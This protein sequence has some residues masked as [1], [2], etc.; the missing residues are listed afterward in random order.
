SVGDL[1]PASLSCRNGL[2]DRVRDGGIGYEGVEG[3]GR[4][5][6]QPT[7][8]LQN[9]P[10]RVLDERSRGMD[11]RE[12]SRKATI[13]GVGADPVFRR[14]V[15][16]PPPDFSVVEGI[17]L[18]HPGSPSIEWLIHLS[19]SL[20]GRDVRTAQDELEA[21]ARQAVIPYCLNDR[22]KRR[23][24]IHEVRKLVEHEKESPTVGSLDAV[25]EEIIP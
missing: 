13:H 16:H 23:R 15:G 20:H 24:G 22:R 3:V 1:V 7:G 10:G 4:L 11:E 14:I 18:D 9:R 6:V 8:R 19:Q 2:N 5:L 17:Y 21:S 25:G 12:M